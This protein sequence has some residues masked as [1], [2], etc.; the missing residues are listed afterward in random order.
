ML[1]TA[2][3]IAT[4]A[5]LVVAASDPAQSSLAVTTTPSTPVFEWGDTDCSGTI[6]TQDLLRVLR[7]AAGLQVGPACD[8]VQ[9]QGPGNPP[10]AD[11]GVTIGVSPTDV[12]IPAGE[13]R[14]VNIVAD[15]TGGPLG[16]WLVTVQYDPAVVTP[17]S[18]SGACNLAFTPDEVAIANAPF[19]GI[20]GTAVL[21]SVTFEAEG[22]AGLHT[23]V[24]VTAPSLTDTDGN[25]LSA[26]L[27][28]GTIVVA[29]SRE[30]LNCQSGVT[31]QDAR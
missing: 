16:S 9:S 29:V 17:V 30:D 25:P 21:A 23:T 4:I 14:S 18:C 24:V 31:A 11:T 8:E 28:N 19:T 27:S 15:V 5:L 6:D 20:S 26:R 1:L 10:I 2:L 22:H 7:R 12:S 3:A 13:Q